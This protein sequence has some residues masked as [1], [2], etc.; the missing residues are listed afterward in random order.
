[1]NNERK[2]GGSAFPVNSDEYDQD[3]ERYRPCSEGGM[4]LRDYFAAK[5]M[6]SVCQMIAGRAHEVSR[7]DPIGDIAKEAYQLADA[8]LRAREQA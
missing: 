5:A 7:S 4:S 6:Q 3:A 2:D 8:M 1:M